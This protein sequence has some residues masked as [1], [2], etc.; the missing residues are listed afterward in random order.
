MNIAG[1][2]TGLSMCF[3]MLVKTFV[4]FLRIGQE[5]IPLKSAFYFFPPSLRMESDFSESE[6]FQFNLS[7]D[8]VHKFTEPF[9][10]IRSL[11]RPLPT[12]QH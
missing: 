3:D 8:K 9:L 2:K 12:L 5:R 10:M 6:S 11:Q 1:T 7:E 4:I